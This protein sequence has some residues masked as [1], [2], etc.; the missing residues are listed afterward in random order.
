[1]KQYHDLLQKI[2]DEGHFKEDR[3]GTGTLSIFGHQMRFNLQEGFP[4]VTTRK[5]HT[6]SLIYELLWFLKGDTNTKYLNDN[7]VRIWNDWADENGDLG[8]IYGYQWRTWHGQTGEVVDQIS[9]L[10]QDLQ[11]KPHSRRLIVSALECCR[12]SKDGIG[13]LSQSF[14]VL[15]Q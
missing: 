11:N 5:I 14:S 10:M 8:P 6:R 13:A 3:T 1:M 2:L 12:S 7:K 15:C 9:Q 4:L